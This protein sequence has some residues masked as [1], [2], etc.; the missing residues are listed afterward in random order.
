MIGLVAVAM[1]GCA[2]AGAVGTPMTVQPA[3]LPKLAGGWQGT[4][5][6][7][8]TGSNQP[9]SLTIKPDNTYEMRVGAFTATGTVQAKDGRLLVT[10]TTTTGIPPERRVSDA[11][12]T[13][14][15]GRW[16]I[17]GYGHSDRGP[18]SYELSKQN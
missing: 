12:V 13:R 18:F 3:D 6:S 17:T 1:A 8:L 2:T 9:A 4:A 16:F 7:G 14:R 5:S 15:D 11:V 10:N